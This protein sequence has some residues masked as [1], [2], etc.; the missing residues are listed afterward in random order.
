MAFILANPFIMRNT[1][2]F[3]A[4]LLSLHTSA[5]V[6]YAKIIPE[7][8][9]EIHLYNFQYKFAKTIFSLRSKRLPLK[10]TLKPTFNGGSLVEAINTDNFLGTKYAQV[11]K[12]DIRVKIYITKK[13]DIMF[14]SQ[15][16]RGLIITGDILTVSLLFRPFR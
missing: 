7:Y 13:I 1:L 2:C 3:I 10:F 15:V 12:Y 6:S 16:N 5:Q 11:L 14:R 4:L 8:K 9:A